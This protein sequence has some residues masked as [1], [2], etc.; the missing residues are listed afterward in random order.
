ML[1]PEKKLVRVAVTGA[2]GQICYSL[3]PMIASGAMLGPH[4][5]VELRLL[6]I[7]P[8]QNVLEGVRM[9]LIDSAFALLVS[10]VATS[11]PRVAFEG[12]DICIMCGA[13]PR[14]PGMERKDLLEVN[15]KIFNEQGRVISEVAEPH[16]RVVVVGNPANTNGLLLAT[17]ARGGKLDARN[18]TVLTRL[19]HNRSLAQLSLRSGVAIS[20]VKN[21]IIW[22]NHSGTQVPDVNS[23]L[24]QGR[25]ARDV[26]SDDAFFDG[27]FIQIVQQRGAEVLK[28]RGLSAGSSTARAIVDHVHDWIRGT[29]HGTF[30]SMGVLSDGNPYSIPNGLLFSFPVTCHG[31]QWKIMEG[32]TIT[33]H[34]R[35]LIENTTKE[36]LEEKQQAGL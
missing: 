23:A 17:A 9:E 24:V 35:S 29:P 1:F 7:E 15:A 19:D 26:C 3:L 12:A 36:L 21:T 13:M 31:G 34:I 16:C 5:H 22:G 32:L 4:Q 28:A 27:P 6:D 11:D 2:A 18:V 33:P 10:V 20:E 14:K 30:V 8:A 25:S